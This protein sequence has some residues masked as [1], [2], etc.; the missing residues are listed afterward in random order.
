MDSVSV[1]VKTIIVISFMWCVAEMIMP[2]DSIRKYSSFIYGLI[3]ISLTVSA[4]SKVKFDDFF[5][6]FNTDSSTQ[7]NASYIREVYEKKLEDI[8][9]E[10]FDN[11]SI[12]VELTD[13]YKVKRIICDDQKTYDD[14][15]RYL[16]EG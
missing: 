2:N 8:L 7:Y 3:I 11:K 6:A 14:V 5:V 16:N 12:E 13:E 1:F 10:K 15:M 9:C 4:F